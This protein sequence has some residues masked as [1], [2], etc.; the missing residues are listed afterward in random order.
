MLVCSSA[1]PACGIGGATC[2]PEHLLVHTGASRCGV[3]SFLQ[4]V[5]DAEGADI[6]W[7]SSPTRNFLSIPT[8][9]PPPPPLHSGTFHSC[10]PVRCRCI[11]ISLS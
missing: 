6:L 1:Q 11:C 9:H 8:S 5:E 4:A 2:C 7:H 3:G 10:A